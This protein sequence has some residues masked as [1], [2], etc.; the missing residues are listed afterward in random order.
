MHTCN[1]CILTCTHLIGQG[2]LDTLEKSKAIVDSVFVRE[3]RALLLEKLGRVCLLTYYLLTC[4]RSYRLTYFLTFF[5]FLHFLLSIL[6]FAFSF[7]VGAL[8]IDY[9]WSLGFH[10][11]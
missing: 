2:A 6:V 4:L 3:T 9:Y 11:E 10:S 8:V 7:S 5:I 1:T